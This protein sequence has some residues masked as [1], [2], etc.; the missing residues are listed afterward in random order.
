VVK[1][2]NKE[3][4]AYWTRRI[5]AEYQRTFGGCGSEGEFDYCIPNLDYALYVTNYSPGDELPELIER[6]VPLWHIVYNGILLNN[7]FGATI[8]YKLK[9]PSVQLK[10]PKY[11]GRPIFYYYSRFRDF[12][13]PKMDPVDLRCRD[14]EE[15][16][17]GVQMVKQGCDEFSRLRHLAVGVHGRA[18]D[19][20]RQLVSNDI[21]RRH[22][23]RLQL[24]QYGSCPS[25][26]SGP[27]HGIP[28]AETAERINLSRPA[29]SMN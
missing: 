12:G 3:G 19:D 9:S 14:D 13:T 25:R 26:R 23:H 18:Q 15:L 27:I 21:L 5:F 28:R 11:G 2:L 22:T 6:R 1:A 4:Y 17:R 24:Q 16:V 8:N 20:R 10:L 7:P 29:C